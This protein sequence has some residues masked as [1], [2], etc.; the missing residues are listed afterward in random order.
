MRLM[1]TPVESLG[2]GNLGSLTT[3]D[4]ISSEFRARLLLALLFVRR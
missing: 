2:F 1:E 3:E 4:F